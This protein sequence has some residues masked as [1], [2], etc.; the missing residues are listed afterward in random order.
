QG[1]QYIP[2]WILEKL[3]SSPY[4]WLIA[5]RLKQLSPI[6]HVRPDAPPFL[7]I[8]G[9][10]DPLV[11]LA[12]SRAMCDRM[13][14]MGASCELYTVAGAGHGLRWWESSPRISEPYKRE[15][16]RWLRQQL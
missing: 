16:V 10:A 12:Q 14:N 15:I 4:S 6:E 2:Q 1:S 3:Q 5:A 13:K 8:H 9:T 7:L 11:P